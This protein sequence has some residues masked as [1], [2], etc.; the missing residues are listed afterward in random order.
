MFEHDCPGLF[1]QLGLCPSLL[2]RTDHTY[3]HWWVLQP[4]LQPLSYNHWWV[5]IE[6]RTIEVSQ[7]IIDGFMDSWWIPSII[8]SAFKLIAFLRLRQLCSPHVQ[9]PP[10]LPPL[11]DHWDS[12]HALCPRRCWR[13]HG[14]TAPGDLD[15][16]VM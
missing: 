12:F 1:H 3:N 13:H 7:T 4:S 5:S 2:L 14:W 6:Y 9:R 10:V 15:L 16:H 8:I 11:R